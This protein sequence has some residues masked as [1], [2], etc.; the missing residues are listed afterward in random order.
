M[1]V[2]FS[3]EETA[4]SK[5]KID[6]GRGAAATFGYMVWTNFFAYTAIAFRTS[7]P[8]ALQVLFMPH[9]FAWASIGE[10]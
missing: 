8:T 6:G 2:R 1:V 5:G 7:L 3:S 10:F 4:E 9:V